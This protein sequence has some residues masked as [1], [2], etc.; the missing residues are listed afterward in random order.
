MTLTGSI[1]LLSGAN[2]GDFAITAMPSSPI[3]PYP[4]PPSTIDV[5]FQPT[6]S[7]LRTATLSIYFDDTYGLTATSPYTVALQ[8]T[9]NQ[10]DTTPPTLSI[11]SPVNNAVVTSASL[12]ING[13]ATDN[14]NGNN[15]VSSVTVNGV[16][17]NNDTASGANTANWSTTVALHSGQNIITVIAT[18]GLG[19]ASP[20]Q[21]RTVTYNPLQPTFGSGISSVSGGK[22]QTTLSGLSA[23]ETIV[24]YSSTDLKNWT[25]VQTNTA[26]GSTMVI[27]NTINPALSGQYFR[28]VVQ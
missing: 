8:G 28:A 2:T 26:A 27:T 3:A 25:P 6:G 18:D 17:A 12:P 9:G 14:G 4:S 13:T 24:I 10:V 21:Q 5:K 11:T 1:V 22:L 16:A 20:S 19:N 15:G 23:G 7:G